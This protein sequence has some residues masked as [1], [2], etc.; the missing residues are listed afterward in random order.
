M[1]RSLPAAALAAALLLPPAPALP[2][3]GKEPPAPRDLAPLLEPLRAKHDLPA[4][5]GAVLSGGALVALGATGVRERGKPEKA[6]TGDRWH[7]GSCTKAMTATLCALLVEE[8]RLSF[9]GTLTAGLGPL[10]A[11]ADPGW[12]AAT[13]AGLLTNRGG[14]SPEVPGP[15]WEAAWRHTG[16]PRAARRALVEG[17]LRDPP[18]ATPGSKFA[19][20]NMNFVLAGAMAEEATGKPWE[21]LMRERLFAP[22][23]METAGFGAP[24]TA[25]AVDQPRGHRADGSPVPPGPGADN[26]PAIG[27]AGTVHASLP[28]WARFVALHLAGA[29]GEGR[30]LKRET[31]ARLHATPGGTGDGYAMGWTVTERP[32][33]GG[34]ALTHAGWNTMWYCVTW[35]APERDF[36]V[37]VCANRGD[38]AAAKACDEAASALIRDHLAR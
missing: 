2:R 10:A 26:P 28:D 20:A 1:T 38:D 37:L 30:L 32:W 23:G 25:K 16:P 33:A 15:L 11:R 18:A 31:F 17:F 36:A 13:L 5:A 21:E 27:P 8:G 4:L 22:L 24:G 9:E 34:R 12:K 29:R 3:E 19:Y 14:A 6:T 7:L 35:L